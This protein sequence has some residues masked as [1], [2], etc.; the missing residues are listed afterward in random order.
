MPK[1]PLNKIKKQLIKEK[2]CL[3]KELSGLARKGKRG[4]RF[5]IKNFG[6]KDDDHVASVATL[7]SEL[8]VGNNLEKSLREVDKALQNVEKGKYGICEICGKDI[9]KP[10]LKVFP[11][12]VT[13]VACERKKN[14][15]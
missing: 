12:A 7:D 5:M 1:I 9:P 15:R 14:K 13:C 3:E 6:S 10:R 2:E 11:A 8:S 4:L